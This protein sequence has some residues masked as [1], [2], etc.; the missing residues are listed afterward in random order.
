MNNLLKIGKMS[1]LN[2]SFSLIKRK[3]VNKLFTRLQSKLSPNLKN[4]G[5]FL[6]STDILRDDIKCDLLRIVVLNIETKLLNLIKRDL[7][8]FDDET[9]ILE[10]VKLSTEDFLTNCYGSKVT[11]RSTIILR[12][13]YSQ[14]LVEN[15][16]IL[17]R[18]PFLELLNSNTKVFQNTFDPIYTTAS[19]KFLEV[20]FDNLIIEIS[21]CV[22]QIIISEF[23]IINSV[24]QVLYRSNFYHPVISIGFVIV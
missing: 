10:L 5:N 20:L 3:K 7:N 24:R 12:S 17:L 19:D 18:V 9:T 21:N 16:N 4:K 15:S 1:T 8:L 6:L 14:F 11:I 22:V 23:S 13:V 2:S